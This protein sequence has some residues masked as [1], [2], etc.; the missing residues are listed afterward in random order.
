LHFK[1]NTIPFRG[2]L[3]SGAAI[4][5]L[6]GN[7]YKSFLKLDHVIIH[8]C[9]SINTVDNT[10]HSS[11]GTM[12]LPLYYDNHTTSVPFVIV[13]SLND[14]FILGA[15]FL[16]SS[17]LA[18]RLF[19]E[20]YA[21][22]CASLPPLLP[23]CSVDSAPPCLVATEELSPS[24]LSRLNHVKVLFEQISYE[25]IGLGRTP[26]VNHVIDT[27]DHAP[28]K[29][30]TFPQSHVRRQQLIEELDRMISLDVVE[31]CKSP[32][33]NNVFI[34]PKKDGSPRFVLDPRKLNSVSKADCY[35][36]PNIDHILSNLRDTKYISALD[37][38]MGFWQMPLSQE[39]KCKTAFF[40]E[41][42]G[43]YCFK[44]TPFGISNI[45]SQLQ[46]LMDALFSDLGDHV[47]CYLD[48][49]LICSPDF[50][51]HLKTLSLVCE[52]LREAKLTI[53][54]SKSEF[55]KSSLKY[56]GHVIDRQGIRTDPEK[57]N[58]MINFPRPTSVK[59][60][61]SFLGCAGYYRKF[62]AHFAEI[63]APLCR[64]TSIKL[65]AAPFLWNE[66]AEKSFVSLKNIMTTA[67]ILKPP[68]YSVPYVLTCDASAVSIGSF[69][70]Q[71]MPDGTEH[72]IAYF[73]R[74]LTS[75]ERSY[76]TTERELLSI[77][78]SV[79]HF[80]SYIDGT[81]FTV[82]SD[83]GCLKYLNN[84]SSPGGRLAR[85]ACRL[86]QY[87][88]DFVYK[89]G[90][91]NNLADALS[92]IEVCA[93]TFPP[94]FRNVTDNSYLN[95]F[96]SCSNN[97]QST[98][99]Y[100]IHNG[101]LYRYSKSGNGVRPEPDGFIWKVVVPS[102]EIG[103]II[104]DYHENFCHPGVDKTFKTLSLTFYWP[105]MYC[106][107]KG[108]ISNCDTCKAYKHNTKAPQ[109]LMTAPKSVSKP[110]VSLSADLIGPL[111]VSNQRF[112]YILTV[113]DNFSKYVWAFP[114]RIANSKTVIRLLEEK[115]F[116]PYSVPRTLIIDNGSQFISKEFRKFTES[117][118][119]RDLYY[120]ARYHPQNNVSERHNANIITALAIL[121]E[122]NQRTWCSKLPKIASCLNNT[123]SI[124]T[125]FTPFFLMHGFEAAPHA[126]F[127][128][129]FSPGQDIPPHDDSVPEYAAGL[130]RMEVV[131]DEVT[132]ALMK[133]FERNA[134]NYNLKRRPCI[135][136]VGQLVWRRAFIQ[137]DA[138]KFIS[139]KLC[140]R[141]IKCQ[142]SK[143]VSDTIYEL[144]E[145]T[146]KNLGRFH[147]KDIVKHD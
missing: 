130:Q 146:G 38:S 115:I 128:L 2:L 78:D 99:N 25:K 101:H 116:L 131:Y 56:L 47:F 10:P 147:V 27:G 37:L 126:S 96:S 70:A 43:Q 28:V 74:K 103:N 67:P 88:F 123:V 120:N 136:R 69:L 60:V 57:I 22:S 42:R 84:L 50:E 73:S 3:D 138:S 36:L 80:R 140:P 95:I 77:V 90:C 100:M 40:V 13:P 75:P 87:S 133:A 134:K 110:L 104:S 14:C 33:L 105:N 45:P 89:K 117:Y 9:L 31:P 35:R 112:C 122:D 119:I 107:V 106:S 108:Y 6:G 29:Q 76:S 44:V 79:H 132:S 137:S 139:A 32:W 98:P 49:I 113:V 71:K 21:T 94:P 1:I 23:I 34:V 86:S 91:E 129:K 109:G 114:L 124:A 39:S 144:C 18:P 16:R 61:K 125:G 102:N 143:R 66:E 15:P 30:K 135:L 85:W 145:L 5:I 41:G 92:R 82:Q 127:H 19:P 46:R 81:H 93:L 97:P 48:D 118:G 121:V 111:P 83:H 65:K 51:T 55:C 141:F 8:G 53:R 72:V 142:V 59:E 17:G 11:I 58:V 7:L 54:L 12:N 64:L 4:N 20:P 24:Q 63:A 62:I 26:L 68:D 52:R